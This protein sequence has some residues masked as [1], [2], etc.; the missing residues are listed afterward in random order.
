M[1]DIKHDNEFN[2]HELIDPVGTE[3]ENQLKET[4]DFEDINIAE[5]IDYVD[6][7]LDEIEAQS[8]EVQPKFRNKEEALKQYLQD[9]MDRKAKGQH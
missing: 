9:E 5:E 3:G 7:S 1:S 6:P 4:R 2:K 8:G